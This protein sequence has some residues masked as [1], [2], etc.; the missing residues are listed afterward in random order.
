VLD[1]TIPA[2]ARPAR[3]WLSWLRASGSD[4]DLLAT[5]GWMKQHGLADE[6]SAIEL[7]RT[8]WG[9]QLPV[10]SQQVWIDWLGDN[11]GKYLKPERIW[12][13]HFLLEPKTSPFDW[14]IRPPAS[15]KVTRQNGLQIQFSATENVW[16]SHVRQ[17]VTVRPGAYRL[18]AE[19]EAAGLTTD[20]HPFFSL[21]DALRP[22][23]LNLR[24]APIEDTRG[25]FKLTLDFTVPPGTQALR[26]QI[27]R[28][29]S[30]RFDN[31]INGTLHVY[32]VSLIP[33]G[34]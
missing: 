31:K 11:A 24:T 19:I 21:T 14:D 20:Q 29:Q 9:R 33:L 18:S 34:S 12:D 30:E 13:P 6:R 22:N 8:L 25:P 16:F 10:A 27:E 15:V 3:S 2:E 26:I 5:W 17:F 28:R 4:E 32:G 23:V 7:T 1:V